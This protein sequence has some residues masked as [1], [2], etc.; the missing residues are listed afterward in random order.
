MRL[1]SPLFYIVLCSAG[2]AVGCSTDATN[3]PELDQLED[4]L[5]FPERGAGGK[6]DS[7]G[8]ASGLPNPV[9]FVH[10]CPPPGFTAEMIAGLWQPMKGAFVAAGYAEEDLYTF[11]Y[12]AEACG[13]IIDNTIELSDLVDEVLW[14]TGA[15][16]VDLVTHS[17][18]A[19]TARLYMAVGGD[20][21]VG[22]VVTIGGANHGGQGA[23][24]G[25][26]LQDMFGYPAYEGMK[27]M[28]PPYACFG[29]SSG[30]AADVQD[31]LNGCLTPSG[32]EVSADETPGGWWV[33]YLS[34]RNELDEIVVPVESACLNQKSQGD[35]SDSDV[36][37]AVR[38]PAGPG[39]C[40]PDGCP[41]HVTMLF[42]PGVIELTLGALE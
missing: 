2:A 36:N 15:W 35:C 5:D 33:D 18:G 23:A 1:A 7:P 13:S 11:V 21:Y 28:F 17:M 22:N 40:G 3:D 41:A 10:G 9:I 14:E 32:R 30:G 37:V 24:P 39:P 26:A 4:V 12:S 34:I 20:W 27:E 42:D 38:V 19:L 29:E 31:Y 8:S 16:E 25:E 6:A